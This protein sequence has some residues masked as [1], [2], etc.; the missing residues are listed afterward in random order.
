MKICFL[1]PSGYGKSTAIEILKKHYDITNIKLAEPLYQMQKEFYLHLGVDIRDRQ[2]G[3]LLQFYGKKVRKE[4]S[5]YL[6]NVF[7]EK[8]D[9]CET[10]II[11]N[12]DCRPDDYKFL[13]DNGFIFIK[14]NGYKRDRSD[15]KTIANSKD[16]LEWQCDI[17]YDYEINNDSSLENFEKNLIQLMNKILVP[18]CYII[19]TGNTC[20][21]DCI[22][23]IS[24]TRDYK[25]KNNLLEVDDKFIENI[26]IL[27]KH[28]VTKFEITGGGEPFINKKLQNIVITIKKIIPNSYIKLYTNGNILRK[29]NGVDEIDISI[30][31][32]DIDT[33]NKF[34]NGNNIELMD[35]LKFFKEDSV[36]LRLSIPLIKGAVDSKEKLDEF[37]EYTKDYVDEYVVRTLYPNTVDIDELY[38]DFDYEHEKV[39]MERDNDIKEFNGIILWS[40]NKFYNSWD[41]KEQKYFNSYLLLKPDSKI[42]INEIEELIKDKGFDIVNRYILKEF[43]ERALKLYKDKDE[44]YLDIINRHLE[45]IS[46]LFGNSAMVLLLNKNVSLDELYFDTYNLKKEIREKFSFTHAH[47]GYLIKDNNLSHANLVHCPDVSSK[48]YDRDLNYIMSSNLME[49]D[50]NELKLIKRYRSFDI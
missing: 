50:D 34:M 46:C 21:C 5:E 10:S 19:P 49:I 33:N 18:K 30:V 1:A 23:C 16:K 39:I 35:K 37:I 47:G 31:S 26:Y 15:D 22:F 27:K 6:L 41:L 44:D 25:N 43:K 29:I 24:K 13:K 9:K 48:L 12:D 8:L 40:D 28:G 45:N 2:D 11:T 17:P 42:Y 36:K 32:K 38:V 14:I 20:N 3:E 4:N 7:K